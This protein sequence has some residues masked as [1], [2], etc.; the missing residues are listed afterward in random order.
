MLKQ[1]FFSCKN[2]IN[3]NHIWS[4]WNRIVFL[5]CCATVWVFCTLSILIRNIFSMNPAF[6]LSCFF[7]S[8]FFCKVSPDHLYPLGQWLPKCAWDWWLH[9]CNGY[10]EFYFFFLSKRNNVF[11]K[12]NRGTSV[13][14]DYFIWPLECLIKK[15]PVSMKWIT[16]ILIKVK[17]YS[18]LLCMLLICIHS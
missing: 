15:L 2:D 16:I 11:V 4:C 18:A 12:S 6:A 17:L 8:F 3:V 14:G 5:N 7:R 9:F 1:V 13:I 10:F